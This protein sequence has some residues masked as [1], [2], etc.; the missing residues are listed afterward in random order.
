VVLYDII[1]RFNAEAR[2]EAAQMIKQFPLILL[3]LGATLLLPAYRKD[4][5]QEKAVP[6]RVTE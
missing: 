6:E 1:F 5:N 4:F 2:E 3:Y